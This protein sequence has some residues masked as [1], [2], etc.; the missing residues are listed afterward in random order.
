LLEERCRRLELEMEQYKA[1]R[2]VLRDSKQVPRLYLIE[3]EYRM[4]LRETE[5]NW[6]RQLIKDIA[7]GALEGM[8]QWK[9]FHEQA[10]QS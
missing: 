4:A 7:T 1:F 6:T 10:V 8:E 9:K 3:S 5:L 2:K